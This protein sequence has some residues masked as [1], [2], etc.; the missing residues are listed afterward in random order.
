MAMEKMLAY[1]VLIIGKYKVMLG[2]LMSNYSMFQSWI[3]IIITMKIC[4]PFIGHVHVGDG[5]IRGGFRI[6]IEMFL[7]SRDSSGYCK[8]PNYRTP[9]IV[10]V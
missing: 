5:K 9:R 1:L 3:S 4:T 2:E 10:N 6:Q 8:F 7:C